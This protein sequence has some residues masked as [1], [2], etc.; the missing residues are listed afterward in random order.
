[1]IDLIF[2]EL[3]LGPAAVAR[4]TAA[5]KFDHP[6]MICPAAPNWLANTE[7]ADV[8]WEHVTLRRG[9]AAQISRLEGSDLGSPPRQRARLPTCCSASRR[10]SGISGPGL[11]AGAASRRGRSCKARPHVEVPLNP[12]RVTGANSKLD[13]RLLNRYT[14]VL[15]DD[16]EPQVVATRR[17]MQGHRCALI[18]V[19]PTV[20]P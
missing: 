10:G 20:T 13:I 16:V 18:G 15:A 8:K 1:M 14:A 9:D 11:P 6:L 3:P 2:A 7:S 12:V 4:Q 17:V 19:Q 5:P